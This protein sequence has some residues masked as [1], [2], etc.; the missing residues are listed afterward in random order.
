METQTKRKTNFAA[1][2]GTK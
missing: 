1:S 2:V